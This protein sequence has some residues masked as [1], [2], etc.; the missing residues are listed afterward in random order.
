MESRTRIDLPAHVARP[1]E[2]YVNGVAQAEGTDYEV[3]GS[4]LLFFRSLQREGSLGFWRWAR[5][6]LGIAGSYGKND[7]VDVVFTLKGRR[8]VVS[9]A[10]PIPEQ[11]AEPAS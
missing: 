8:T 4:S 6:V 2:V 10:A 11:A 3:V 5:M 1:F 7:T 9:L